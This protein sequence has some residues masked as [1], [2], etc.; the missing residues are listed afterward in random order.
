MIQVRPFKPEDAERLRDIRLRALEDSPNAFSAK[1][2]D[3]QRAPRSCWYEILRRE[4]R[5][6]G[7]QSF[8][9]TEAESD[10]GMAGGYPE[11]PIRYRLFGMWVAPAARRKGV[12]GELLW[13]CLPNRNVIESALK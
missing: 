9:A 13:A 3:E 5:F 1:L 10:V 11:S 7:S 6:A 12:G 2:A 8:L 4:G